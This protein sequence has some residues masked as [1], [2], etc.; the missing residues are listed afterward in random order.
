MKKTLQGAMEL[1]ETHR[2]FFKRLFSGSKTPF[3]FR[4]L[5]FSL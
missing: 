3:K 4:F 1:T 5:R 2:E